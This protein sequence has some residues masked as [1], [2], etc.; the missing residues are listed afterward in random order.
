MLEVYTRENTLANRKSPFIFR[1]KNCGTIGKKEII[2]RIGEYNSTI[3]EADAVAVFTIFEDIFWNYIYDG[4]VVKLFMG[5]FRAGA[6]GSAQRLLETF[7]PKKVNYKGAPKRDHGF[8]LLFSSNRK[9]EEL[10]ES[11]IKFERLREGGLCTP[12]I[13]SIYDL[14]SKKHKIFLPDD[15]IVIHGQYLKID[16]TD[17][18]QGVFLVSETMDKIRINRYIRNTRINLGFILP[19]N[20]PLGEYRVYVCTNRAGKYH[21]T[22]IHIIQ[23]QKEVSDNS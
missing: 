1:S 9:A 7:R 13:S 11:K 22:D 8:S 18:E 2:K 21:N 16:C 14:M 19:E 10:F 17:M 3:T 12:K 4:Y 20:I 5:S 23:I 6:Y 15:L